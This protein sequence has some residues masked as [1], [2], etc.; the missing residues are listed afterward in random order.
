V[1]P[2]KDDDDF[3]QP[4]LSHDINTK[5]PKEEFLKRE[6]FYLETDKRIYYPGD[7][8]DVAVHL[9]TY[10]TLSRVESLIIQIKGIESFR[11]N[12]KVK[13]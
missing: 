6:F 5:I 7:V 11:F 4:L 3:M 2:I 10:K 1:R 13:S 12:S 9:R 8:I